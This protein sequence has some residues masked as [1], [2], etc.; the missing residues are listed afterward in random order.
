MTQR[1]VLICDA[2]GAMTDDH[3]PYP[4][5]RA[6]LM[7]QGIG[8][9]YRRKTFGGSKERP[10]LSNRFWADLC[11]EHTYEFGIWSEPVRPTKRDRT[12]P[13]A[14]HP[15]TDIGDHIQF[16]D[17]QLLLDFEEG[18]YRVYRTIVQ[19]I[20]PAG[21]TPRQLEQLRREFFAPAARPVE[22]AGRWVTV[23][24]DTEAENHDND[25][26]SQLDGPGG[27]SPADPQPAQPAAP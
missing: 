20:R 22:V 4:V 24:P 11:P 15:Q 27:S 26:E 3:Y 12:G 17:V 6:R 18:P 5:S 25:T 9:R 10:N 21:A 14:I 8:W 13:K 2:C 7:A 23:V 19:A 1:F 16:P